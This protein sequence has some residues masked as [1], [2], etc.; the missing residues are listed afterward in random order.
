MKPTPRRAIGNFVDE[1]SAVD[2]GASAFNPWSSR[3]DLR[4]LA[5]DAAAGRRDR[6][7]RFLDTTPAIALV[8]EA[9]GFQGCRYAGVPFTCIGRRAIFHRI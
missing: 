7:A 1:L 9:P 8:G 5:G 4:D 3:C 6:L 2:V